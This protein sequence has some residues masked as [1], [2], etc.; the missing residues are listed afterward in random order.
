LRK[1]II[2]ILVAVLLLLPL[3]TL[4]VF[5]APILYGSNGSGGMGGTLVPSTLYTIN[6]S[7]GAAT[8]VGLIGFNNCGA[9]DFHPGL[10][11]LYAI[12]KDVN[13]ALV[14][15]TINHN[16]GIGTFVATVTG[17]I[18]PATGGVMDVSFRN[19]DSTLFV[20]TLISG[21][22]G[23]LVELH[24]IN[25][26]SGASTLVGN[27]I[28]ASSP[29]NGLAFSPA[30]TLFHIS[31]V[32]FN[33]LNQGT[34]FANFIAP[35]SWSP[36]LINPRDNAMDF[37]PGTGILFSSTNDGSMG[38]GPNY[39]STVNTATGVVT[40]IGQTVNGLDA[41]AF[42]PNSVPI[43]GTI[44]PIDT[45]SLL[46]VGVHTTTAWLIPFIIAAV[47]FG[48]VILRKF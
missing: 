8:P 19:S 37:E 48:L 26:G 23:P 31:L 5:A 1:I 47:G 15:I 28:F 33:F 24:T 17:S 45:A 22:G 16:T 27:L 14:L 2:P 32:F 42:F 44:V 39:L 10:T 41:I 11:I 9:M 29:G 43:G 34:G 13:G 6:T 25:I 21:G 3:G 12:C 40:R 46:L 18:A 38:S 36:P 20:T 30:D 35:T 7:T 4:Q